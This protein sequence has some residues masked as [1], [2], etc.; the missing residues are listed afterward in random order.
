MRGTIKRAGDGRL[1][2]E[3]RFT[4]GGTYDSLDLPKE[5]GDYGTI[6]LEEGSWWRHR[7]YYSADGS[8][9]G[10]IYN[11]NTPV[12][13]Y[14]RQVRYVD[15]EVDVVLPPGGG[16]IVVDEPALE[17]SVTQGLLP[18]LLAEKA[19]GLA[20]ELVERLLP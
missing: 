8:S 2:L 15:L 14:P 18:R 6:D 13:F 16:I 12:E 7:R 1:I 5:A 9:K 3:R 17:Q 10:D 20:R 4:P 19:R 11:I